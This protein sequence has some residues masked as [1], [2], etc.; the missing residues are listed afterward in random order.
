MP[1]A[2]PT[3]SGYLI[4][5]AAVTI[6][7]V[8]FNPT[9]FHRTL[10]RLIGCDDM[11]RIHLDDAHV[12]YC[13]SRRTTEPVTGLWT[14]PARGSRPPIAGRAV[15]VGNN[16]ASTPG[17]PLRFFA[18]TISV[19][20]PVIIPDAVAL[21]RLAELDAADQCGAF[22]RQVRIDGF[23]LE[24]ERHRLLTVDDDV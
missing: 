17:L 16:G 3:L 4:D 1:S 18:A 11:E 21:A 12:A 7:A 5:P 23:Q 6:R 8:E 19:Y 24:V 22:R 20:R 10:R 15:I 2:R 14:F 9:H 13:D